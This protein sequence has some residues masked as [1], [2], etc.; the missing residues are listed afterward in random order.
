MSD[1]QARHAG[2]S[3]AV[4]MTLVLVLAMTGGGAADAAAARA[5]DG[6]LSGVRAELSAP[7]SGTGAV[8]RCG[9]ESWTAGIANVC[10]G[11]VVYRDYVYD[12]YG[13]N[14]D[15]VA[16][17]T[18]PAPN[19]ATLPTGDERYGS[20]EE[21]TADLRELRVWIE[22]GRLVVRFTVN[23]LFD[24]ASTAGALAVDT[25]NDVATGGGRW[26]VVDVSSRGWDTAATFRAGMP[27]VVV[28]TS[29][30]T[31]TGSVPKPA[32]TR[33]R[34]HAVTARS[35]GTVMNVG[36]RGPDERG[37]WFEDHQGAAL[38]GGDISEFGFTVDVA[39]LERKVT[40]VAAVGPGMRQR[41]YRSDFTLGQG[42]G[43][44]YEGIPGENGDAVLGQKF[45]FFGAY[46]PYAVYVPEKPGPHGL[47][48]VLHGMCDPLDYA[49]GK[50]GMQQQFGEARN[51]VMITPL[52]RGPAGWYSGAAE[53]D[54]L[55]AW[56]DAEV[57]YGT[58][59]SRV[60]VSGYSM[61][62]YGTLRL[63]TLYPDRFA[64]FVDWVGYT[65]CLNGAPEAGSC[66]A[67]YG[68]NV[69]PTDFVGNL[70]WVPGAMLYAG[71]DALVQPTSAVALQEAMAATGYPY[72]WWMHPAAEHGTFHMTGDW[73]K[74]SLYSAPWAL[75]VDPPRATYRYDPDLDEPE[76]LLVH[77]HAY[78]VSRLTTAGDGRGE[79]DLTSHGCGGNMPLTQPT[80]G[81]GTD[82][83]PWVSRG[84]AVVGSQPLTR[85]GRLAGSLANISG[86]LVDVEA[87]CLARSIIHYDITTDGPATVRFSDGR[88]LTLPAGHH[89]GELA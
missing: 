22:R 84:A 66:P 83:V 52:A 57:V 17:N 47:Q 71:A 2:L 20:G 15:L 88:V 45:H 39:D 80:A 1:C 48:L 24:E 42:E 77:D 26:P 79:V 32:G 37:P 78:W 59:P 14:T 5:S 54:V 76:Y 27:G 69:N 87:T 51:R 29:D 89:E 9:S 6:V 85:E 61:G 75:R 23:T 53:R 72:N 18:C 12:D 49:V 65:D 56:Q 3:L 10:S 28:D 30:N 35:D 67:G 60:V 25:D 16:S 68:A 11:T 13:A 73:R 19:P 34:L 74:E 21:N 86:L 55:D 7:K 33:W 38:A 50:T 36:F 43:M 64:G 82:P 46:Q 58:D 41:V 81:V 40:R 8:N 70:R 63:A 31:I 62:G 4:G 44:T